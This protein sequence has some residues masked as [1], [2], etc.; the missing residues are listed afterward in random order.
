VTPLPATTCSARTTASYSA[1]L[2]VAMPNGIEASSRSWPWM[3]MMKPA[4]AGPGFGFF[5]AAPSRSLPSQSHLS[6]QGPTMAAH[7][8]VKEGI[9]VPP[10]RPALQ[11]A[12][13]SSAFI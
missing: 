6:I 12:T 1:V 3:T 13:R 5:R 7:H 4:P 2:F 9:D 10:G 8:Y 11:P